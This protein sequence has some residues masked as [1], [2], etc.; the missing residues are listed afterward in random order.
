[1]STP[2]ARARHGRCCF[3]HLH[4][5]RV[6]PQAHAL[7]NHTMKPARSTSRSRLPSL[8]FAATITLLAI[9]CRSRDNCYKTY[10]DR[11]A[12]PT[13][14]AMNPQDEDPKVPPAP[15]RHT[16]DSLP[17]PRNPNNVPR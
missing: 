9:G 4:H 16:A 10:P 17:P 15:T 12:S 8:F 1:M 6:L 3:L 2:N 14:A 7:Y 11:A 5:P 13:E